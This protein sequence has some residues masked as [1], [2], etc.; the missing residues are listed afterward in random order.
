MET[1][2]NDY[3]NEQVNKEDEEVVKLRR[4]KV[5][6]ISGDNS[7]N[8]YSQSLL[9]DKDL[10][11]LRSQKQIKLTTEFNRYYD[12]GFKLIKIRDKNGSKVNDV[13]LDPLN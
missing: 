2:F 7:G 1:V 12:A 4:R 3:I 10:T 13:L 11:F 9:V 8:K 6:Y 5:P